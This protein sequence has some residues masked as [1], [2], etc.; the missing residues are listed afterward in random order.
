M[1]LIKSQKPIPS[2]YLYIRIMS[3]CYFPLSL[4]TTFSR[5]KK[6]SLHVREKKRLA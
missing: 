4:I 6:I 5:K 3:L 1:K 2:A